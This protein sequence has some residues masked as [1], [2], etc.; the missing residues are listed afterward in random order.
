MSVQHISALLATK[1]TFYCFCKGKTL[2]SNSNLA[3]NLLTSE[4]DVQR[5]V[6]NSPMWEG[7]RK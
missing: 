6:T 1:A 4:Q 3:L 2:R 7:E 5:Q